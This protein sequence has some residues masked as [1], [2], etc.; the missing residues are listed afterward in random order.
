MQPAYCFSV[1]TVHDA[2]ENCFVLAGSGFHG[3]PPSTPLQ[4]DGISPW[5]PVLPPGGSG[6]KSP[7]GR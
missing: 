2:P 5:T 1:N 3:M 7:A 6:T 4:H